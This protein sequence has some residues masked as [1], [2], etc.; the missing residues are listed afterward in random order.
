MLREGQF[1]SVYEMAHRI[2]APQPTVHRWLKGEARPSAPYCIKLAEA[3]GTP[4][5]QVLQMAYG[6][7]LA[8]QLCISGF[9]AVHLSFSGKQ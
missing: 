4:V 2:E 1:R 8:V 6:C 3:T 7:T 9:G 5:E